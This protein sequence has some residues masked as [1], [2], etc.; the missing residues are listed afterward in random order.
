MKLA[1]AL[2]ERSDLQRRLSQLE[3]RLENNAHVQEGESPAEDPKVLLEELD[4]N[5]ARLE[6]LVT[7]IN[8]TN[9]LTQIDGETLTAKLSRRDA[10][11]QRI[12][13]LRDFLR[14]AS[15]LA[16]R[17]SRSEIKILSTVP[18]AQLQKK[19][20]DLSKQLRLL[21]ERIQESNWTTDL[22]EI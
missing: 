15:N 2:S 4:A 10:L 22:L 20:D 17:A 16:K 7:R 11:K 21:D 18:V 3:Y 12:N 13:I 5:S 8:L 1:T 14:E 19:V 6:E 9:A